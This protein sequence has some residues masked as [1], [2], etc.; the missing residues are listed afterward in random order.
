MKVMRVDMPILYALHEANTFADQMGLPQVGLS[1]LTGM[2]E[3]PSAKVYP[4]FGRA[5]LRTGFRLPHILVLPDGKY[6]PYHS[7][8]TG[9]FVA[10]P[11]GGQHI[12]QEPLPGMQAPPM[13]A[14]PGLP[15]ELV[16]RDEIEAFMR[17]QHPGVEFSFKGSDDE[18]TRDIC[19]VLHE[20]LKNHPQVEARVDYIGTQ[21]DVPGR[22]EADFLTKEGM[23]VRDYMGEGVA[24]VTGGMETPEGFRQFMLFNDNLTGNKARWEELAASCVE[25]GFHREAKEGVSE[26]TYTAKHEAAHLLWGT[27]IDVYGDGTGPLPYRDGNFG[28][29]KGIVEVWFDSHIGRAQTTSGYAYKGGP[30]E[31]IAEAYS[32]YHYAKHP[33]RFGGDVVKLFDVMFPGG[34]AKP[35]VPKDRV[36][37]ETAEEMRAANKIIA[38]TKKKLGVP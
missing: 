16:H 3:Y 35:V 33:A 12:V 9:R 20:E 31:A 1:S 6:N 22:V 37:L 17:D 5:P 11:G 29:M 32:Q 10:H 18:Q 7:H 2:Q 8:E 23:S 38:R 26:A 24:G 15:K 13:H 30:R 19:A 28:T 27:M 36:L 21:T 25:S 4:A 14:P 34:V